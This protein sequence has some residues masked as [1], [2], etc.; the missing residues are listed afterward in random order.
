MNVGSTRGRRAWPAADIDDDEDE[1]LNQDSVE[2]LSLQGPSAAHLA[3]PGGQAGPS[4]AQ[5]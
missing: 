3:G 2:A 5:Q 1:N 4:S